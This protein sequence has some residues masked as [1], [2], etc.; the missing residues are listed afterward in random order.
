MLLFDRSP[1]ESEMLSG[2]IREQENSEEN[3]PQI[4]HFLE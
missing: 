3:R 1:P 4:L 2:D